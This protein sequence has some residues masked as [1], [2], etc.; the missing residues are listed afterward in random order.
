MI[1]DFPPA[2]FLGTS[3]YCALDGCG[4][5]PCRTNVLPNFPTRPDLHPDAVGSAV[6]RL[7]PQV[8]ANRLETLPPRL[9]CCAL[10]R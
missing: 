2:S 8:S 3:Q 5:R 10:S 7:G 4:H 6:H 9:G 1:T